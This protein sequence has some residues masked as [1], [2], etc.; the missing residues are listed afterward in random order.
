METIIKYIVS[1]ITLIK[2]LANVSLFALIYFS[3]SKTI[4]CHLLSSIQTFSYLYAQLNKMKIPL[5]LADIEIKYH[6]RSIKEWMYFVGTIGLLVLCCFIAYYTIIYLKNEI[7]KQ[8]IEETKVETQPE[9][10]EK[11]TFTLDEALDIVRDH[12]TK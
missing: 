2:N 6:H 12:F 7:T 5:F 9:E 1:K 8:K 11:R 3:L 4:S 10:Q